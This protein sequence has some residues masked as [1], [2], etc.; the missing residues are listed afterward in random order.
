MWIS[1]GLDYFN[2]KSYVYL[3]LALTLGAS[4]APSKTD[5]IS[6]LPG[7]IV[8]VAAIYALNYLL[9]FKVYNDCKTYMRFIMSFYFSFK[10]LNLFAFDPHKRCQ[11]GDAAYNC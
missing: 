6:M 11:H 4:A 5:I 2:W 10:R 1:T 3:Y 8:I 9:A 7:L